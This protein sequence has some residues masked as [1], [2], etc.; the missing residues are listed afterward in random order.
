MKEFLQTKMKKNN[1]YDNH[2]DENDEEHHY[3]KKVKLGFP[4]DM[5]K[6]TYW[7]EHTFKVFKKQMERHFGDRELVYNCLI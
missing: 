3:F 5:T 6:Y 4:Y 2:D 7:D 1:N